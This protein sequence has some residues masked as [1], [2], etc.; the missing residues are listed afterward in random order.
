[1]TI[2]QKIRT[3]VCGKSYDSGKTRFD[4]SVNTDL[5]QI[6]WENYKIFPSCKT[7]GQRSG[8]K[9]LTNAILFHDYVG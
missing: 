3:Y 9:L 1:M 5:K 8:F 4:F 2:Q 6:S 7:F